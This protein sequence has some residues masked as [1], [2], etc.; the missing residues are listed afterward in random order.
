MMQTFWDIIA[1]IVL[2]MA[3]SLFFGDG[4]LFNKGIK[5]INT[6]LNRDTVEIRK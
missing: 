5:G 6:I 4:E 1:L 3:I 2:I